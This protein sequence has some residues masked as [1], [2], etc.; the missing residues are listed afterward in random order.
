MIYAGSKFLARYKLANRKT[1]TQINVDIRE[2]LIKLGENA[3]K[4]I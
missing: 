4:R 2:L 3:Q 1:F